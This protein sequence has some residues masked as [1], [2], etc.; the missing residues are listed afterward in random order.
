MFRCH[1]CNDMVET[2]WGATCNNCRRENQEHKDI[3]KSV[4]TKDKYEALQAKYDAL[5]L[6]YKDNTD[7]MNDLELEHQELKFKYD[8]LKEK[9]EK[10]IKL[11]NKMAMR[12]NGLSVYGRSPD[13][14]PGADL[15]VQEKIMRLY[16]VQC[17]FETV[18][19]E[20]DQRGEDE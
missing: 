8:S 10:L 5:E 14:F 18:L 20:Y 19:A 3:L 11:A 4:C 12:S 6:V 13:A 15:Y 7:E 9:S 2:M 17:A 1:Q 16:D